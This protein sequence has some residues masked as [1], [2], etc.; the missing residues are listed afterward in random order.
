VHARD[1]CFPLAPGFGCEVRMTIDALRAGL[2][3]EEVDLDLDHR[4][5]ARDAA[6]FLHRG[7]QL[8]DAVLA[9]GPLGVNYRGLRLPLAGWV[10]FNQSDP[11]ISVVT[12]LGFLDDAVPA[13]RHHHERWDGAGY[14]D[15]LAGDEIP[16]GARIIHV[17][18]ALDSMLTNRIYRAARPAAEALDELRQ[19][20]GSQ[21]CPR[22]VGALER[23]L[24]RD[25]GSEQT[26]PSPLAAAS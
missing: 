17:A 15:G 23:L 22:C 20:G 16:L 21:F 25:Q 8:L 13:I 6:G 12:L 24:E 11:G 26:S 5:T 19:G 2:T 18:D 10:T 7:R 3:L 4:A 9:A 1:A 14:P